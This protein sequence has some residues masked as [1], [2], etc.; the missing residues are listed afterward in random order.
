MM[1]LVVLNTNVKRTHV[2]FSDLYNTIVNSC[3]IASDM[4]LPK[5]GAKKWSSKVVPGWNEHVQTQQDT[6]LFWHHIWV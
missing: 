2:L 6:S 1:L 5:T 4:C 3:I